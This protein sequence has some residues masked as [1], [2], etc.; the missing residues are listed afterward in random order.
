MSVSAILAVKGRNVVTVNHSDSVAETLQTLANNKIG[1]AI[2][3]KDEKVCGIVSERDLVR[4]IAKLGADALQ[5]AISEC[6]TK[7][8]ISAKE[9]DTIDS[10]MTAMS[11]GRFRHMPVMDG[12]E[13]IGLISI[14]DVVKQKIQQA[15]TDVEEMKKYIAG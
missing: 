6:M 13:L 7:A 4:D 9:S 1:A 15:E 8:V 12:D 10:V 14:G 2:V 3:L 11:S 5:H